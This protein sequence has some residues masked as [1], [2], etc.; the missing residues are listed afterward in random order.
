MLQYRNGQSIPTHGYELTFQD[1]CQLI[2]D[3][4]NRSVTHPRIAKLLNCTVALLDG[5]FVLQQAGG[6]LI[7]FEV[8]HF[9]LQSD[10]IKQRDLYNMAMSVWR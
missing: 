3:S 2:E 5:R 4:Y 10:P 9:L 8:A 1:F 7:P 6:A